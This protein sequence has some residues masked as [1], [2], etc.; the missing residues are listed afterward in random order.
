MA[1]LSLFSG[2]LE[3]AS[4]PI[5]HIIAVSLQ[6]VMTSGGETCPPLFCGA[7]PHSWR[8]VPVENGQRISKWLSRPEPSQTN[9]K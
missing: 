3:F 6:D 2:R 9:S 5:G 1:E 8:I 7:I 4:F